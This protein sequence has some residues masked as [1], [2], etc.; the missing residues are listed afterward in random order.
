MPGQQPQPLASPDPAQLT[1]AARG[2]RVPLRVL[3]SHVSILLV[4]LAA[5]LVV[6]ALTS[7]A[8]LTEQNLLSI[9]RQVSTVGVVATGA[10]LVVIAGGLDF[11]VGGVVALAGVILGMT[12]GWPFFPSLLVCLAV[13]LCI[14]L[15]NGL[16]TVHAGIPFMIVTVA[17]G[18]LATGA[19]YLLSKGRPI[20]IDSPLLSSLGGDRVGLLPIPA[21][22]FLGV[23][24]LARL[25]LTRTV[26]GTYVYATGGND[27]AAHLSGVPTD[28]VRVLVYTIAGVLSAVGGIVLTA[29]VGVAAP[30]SGG[31]MLMDTITPIFI[32]GTKIMGGVG[33]ISGTVV[34]TLF[35]GVLSNLF[36]TTNLIVHWQYFIK[37]VILLAA[38]YLATRRRG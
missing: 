24:V 37:G 3:N 1:P 9:L 27:E 26:F 29:R 6:G 32:G 2:W 7:P 31:E 34:G 28:R 15:L 17:T 18:T 13:G 10:T 8:F 19:A 4:V 11:S 21:A 16:L 33:S 25:L 5:S 23:A 30:T 35:L 22:V 38:V 36:N 14:G 12:Q 20:Y